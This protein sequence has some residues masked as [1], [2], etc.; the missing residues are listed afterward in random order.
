LGTD[1]TPRA[2]AV[3]SR[4]DDPSVSS[5]GVREFVYAGGAIAGGAPPSV[6]V[7]VP[8]GGAIAGGAAP[9][10]IVGTAAAYVA[11][12]TFVVEP[13]RPEPGLHEH[14]HDSFAGGLEAG[15]GVAMFLVVGG[16]LAARRIFRV[17][18]RPEEIF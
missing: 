15:I 11:I 5:D 1:W 2:N 8:P 13:P 4:C 10:A 3:S 9:T 12:K 6:A 17:R 16:R 14:A 18:T 7:P